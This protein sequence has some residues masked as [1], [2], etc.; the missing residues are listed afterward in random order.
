MTKWRPT[1]LV[2]ARELVGH[3]R[4][5]GNQSKSFGRQ[6]PQGRA[7]KRNKRVSYPAYDQKPFYVK[8]EEFDV[9]QSNF[10]DLLRIVEE[11][12]HPYDGCLPD[13]IT[14]EPMVRGRRPVRADDPAI[15]PEDDFIVL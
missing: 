12:A 5:Y 4:S 14:M 11:K 3:H 1:Q 8:K 9:L 13:G 10:L 7:T 15:I 2:P 6:S